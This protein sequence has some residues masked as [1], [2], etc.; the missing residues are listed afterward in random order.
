MDGNHRVLPN[1]I[2]PNWSGNRTDGMLCRDDDGGCDH[3]VSPRTPKRRFR[4]VG[5]D[6]SPFLH[7]SNYLVYDIVIRE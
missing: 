1:R 5:T 6:R 3:L 7:D 4:H 2:R